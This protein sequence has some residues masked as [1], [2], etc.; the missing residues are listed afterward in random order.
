MP[1]YAPRSAVTQASYRI[2]GTVLAGATHQPIPRITALPRAAEVKS[3]AWDGELCM[4][5]P[6]DNIHYPVAQA[7]L[8]PGVR[9][10][11][12][13]TVAHVL[14]GVVVGGVTYS[15][16]PCRRRAIRKEADDGAETR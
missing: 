10:E 11:D 4:A 16:G 6:A 2:R 15:I 14:D 3:R 7:T 13:V 8:P 5:R 9:S 12:L 1:S